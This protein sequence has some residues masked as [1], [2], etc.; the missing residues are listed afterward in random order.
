MKKMITGADIFVSLVHIVIYKLG[1]QIK[2][3]YIS[4]CS[5]NSWEVICASFPPKVKHML[6]LVRDLYKSKDITSVRAVILFQVSSRV[7]QGNS[8]I[9]LIGNEPSAFEMHEHI[10]EIIQ[11]SLSFAMFRNKWMNFVLWDEKH[12]QSYNFCICDILTCNTAV[13]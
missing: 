12:F 9:V 3:N 7:P 10:R 8:L 5:Q 6:E 1:L 2:K 13:I 11:L 4:R